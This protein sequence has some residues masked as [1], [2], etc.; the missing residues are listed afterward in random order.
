MIS[1]RRWRWALWAA[2]LSLLPPAWSAASAFEIPVSSADTIITVNLFPKPAARAK[3]TTAAKQR[4]AQLRAM[5]EL[6]RRYN[7]K[8]TEKQARSFGE[9]AIQAGD[10]FSQEPFVLAAMII[11]ES[12]AKPNVVSKGG[13]YGLMQVR[14]RIHEK[15][16]RKKYPSVKKAK[17]FLNPKVNILV[18]AELFSEY[19]GGGSVRQGLLRYSAGNK[20]LADRVLATKNELEASY[21]KH[22]KA[23]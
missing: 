10:R 20:Q 17:D 9:Y 14:W 5:A 19:R 18:G 15:R 16:I 8:L 3:R 7:P 12:S 13:D 22:L 11:R 4:E 21:R 23:L 1:L 2:A 6:F